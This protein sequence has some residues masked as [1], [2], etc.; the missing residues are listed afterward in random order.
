[1]PLRW[2]RK[3]IIMMSNTIN[4]V[5]MRLAGPG[6]SWIVYQRLAAERNRMIMG[7]RKSIRM[8]FGQCLFHFFFFSFLRFVHL[9]EYYLSTVHLQVSSLCAVPCCAFVLILWNA[10][11]EKKRRSKE[12]NE[13]KL[14]HRQTTMSKTTK[15]EKKNEKKNEQTHT[16]IGMNASL[17]QRAS[18]TRKSSDIVN[19]M[20]RKKR[21]KG[22]KSRA[23]ENKADKM[24]DIRL[25]LCCFGVHVMHRRIQTHTDVAY[26]KCTRD[27]AISHQTRPSHPCHDYDNWVCINTCLNYCMDAR[28]AQINLFIYLDFVH[29]SGNCLV[30]YVCK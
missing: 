25:P 23:K 4:T 24:L 3:I 21:G 30:R 1:M 27:A 10:M 14:S 5:T 11:H 15:S 12:K 6:R 16:K 8:W 26:T 29:Y 17:Q 18:K 13:S 9:N 19:E 28:S 20:R 7:M 2:P 22:N